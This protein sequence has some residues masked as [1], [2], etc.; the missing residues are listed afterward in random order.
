MGSK[1]IA[2][3]SLDLSRTCVRYV[4]SFKGDKLFGNVVEAWEKRAVAKLLASRN[5]EHFEE[6][7][8]GDGITVRTLNHFNTK[9][10]L[11][12]SGICIAIRNGLTGKAFIV[13]GF[14]DGTAVEQQFP[15]Y[16]PLLK[17]RYLPFFLV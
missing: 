16:C 13:R 9:R 14:V 3:P 4:A 11:T 1:S 6:F 12:F 17:V 8:V 7:K 10:M 15:Y 2:A 5:P